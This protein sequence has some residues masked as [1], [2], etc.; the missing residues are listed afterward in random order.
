M[1]RRNFTILDPGDE[2]EWAQV[3][4][5]RRLKRRPTCWRCGERIADESAYY[6]LSKWFCHSCLE[7]MEVEF[8]DFV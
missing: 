5:E 6:I 3:D 8:D 2:I 4:E 1:L 7:E